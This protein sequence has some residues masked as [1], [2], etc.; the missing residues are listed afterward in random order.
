[1][2]RPESTGADAPRFLSADRIVS[3]LMDGSYDAA[4]YPGRTGSERERTDVS[5]ICANWNRV[6]DG[7]RI[8]RVLEK[9][10]GIEVDWCDQV[11]GCDDC[12]HAV[13]TEPQYW[14]WT[15]SYA[16]DGDCAVVCF[17]CLES[18]G[19]RWTDGPNGYRVVDPEEWRD[20]SISSG[21]MRPEDIVPAMV[22]ALREL[23]YAYGYWTDAH[24][25]WRTI[26]DTEARL[27]AAILHEG[28]P[29]IGWLWD[30]LDDVAPEGCTFGWHPADGAELGF[31]EAE[32]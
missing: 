28:E 10:R 3:A 5:V 7:D 6:P 1:M 25:E 11:Y 13:T 9:R 20:R 16:W 4:W 17:A 29:A 12:G 14:T 18:D 31:W 15:P 26:Q 2:I 32:E 8:Q 21:T 30:R 24:R 23:G 19:K 27:A 22:S